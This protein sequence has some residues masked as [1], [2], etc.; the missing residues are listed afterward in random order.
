LRCERSDSL[1]SGDSYP[2]ITLNVDVASNAP[3]SVTNTVTV[4]GGDLD[5]SDNTKDDLTNI[6]LIPKLAVTKSADAASVSAG[7]SIG[8]TVVVSNSSDANTGTATSATLT[9]NLPAGTG[10]DWSISPAYAGPGTCSVDGSVGSEV[11]NCSFGDLAAG[12]SASVHVT[13]GTSSASCSTY[14][15]SGTAAATN[16]GNV[17]STQASTT[18]QCPSLTVTKTE[19]A[20]TVNAGQTMGFNIVVSNSNAAGTGT[21]TAVTLSDSLPAGTGVDWSINPAYAGPGTCSID[22]AVGSEVLNCSFG[23]MAPG[24]SITVEVES[25]TG[26][27][28]CGTYANTA[29]ASS[30]NHANT[31]D[32]G[33]ITVQ[34]PALTMTKTEG[35]ALVNTGSQISFTIQVNNSNVAGTGTATN[36]ELADTLPSGTGVSW[37]IDASS[38]YSG[39]CDINSGVLECAF[40]DMAPGGSNKVVVVSNTTGAS[41]GPYANT[42][43]LTADNHPNVEDGATTTVQCPDLTM[44]K[45]AD[46]ASV[47]PGNDIGFTITVQNSNAAGTVA[48]TAVTLEDPLPAG[49]GVSWSLTPGYSGTCSIDPPGQTLNCNFGTLDPGESATVHVTSDTTEQ[50]CDTFSNTA[51]VTST[52]HESI[53]ASDAITVACGALVVIGSSGIVDEDGLNIYE[54]R[55]QMATIRNNVANGTVTYRY[56]LPA[57]ELF[58]NGFPATLRFRIRYRDPDNT[59]HVQVLLKSTGVGADGRETLY[60]FDSDGPDSGGVAAPANGPFNQTVDRSFTLPGPHVL[61]GRYGYYLEVIIT[62]TGSSPIDAGFI[63]CAISTQPINP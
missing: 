29:T 30:S 35:A 40:G 37:S 51:T 8:F 9:D 27:S 26:Y 18:V 34:C 1:A 23:D 17:T 60:A 44:T 24:A 57:T 25:A 4:T 55:N 5:K 3:D 20:A 2:S 45:T 46:S 11:L 43:T 54:V 7:T 58:E 13:S 21:A 38:S 48:A 49:P 14:N 56:S 47:Q 61:H 19:D 12:A 50:S 62:K 33:S 31:S 59:T 15:N 22:G 32:N 63:G 10:I 36:V 16:H 42:A 39:T 28:S 52:N 6:T 53:E 41:C